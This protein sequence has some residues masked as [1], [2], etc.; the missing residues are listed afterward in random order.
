MITRYSF[1]IISAFIL[2]TASSC[3]RQRIHKKEI[4]QVDSTKI[5]TAK[6]EIV[7][8]TTIIPSSYKLQAVTPKNIRSDKPK[9]SP[10]SKRKI[11]KPNKNLKVFS[12]IWQ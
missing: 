3:K 5:E 11:R 6:I 1:L 2:L 8:E 4:S 10:K 9:T 7:P 12:K